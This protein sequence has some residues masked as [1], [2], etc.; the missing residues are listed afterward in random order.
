MTFVFSNM[1][2]TDVI[3][4]SRFDGTEEESFTGGLSD[5]SFCTCG[6]YRMH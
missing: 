4:E 2:V 3:N 6:P 5:I 1:E